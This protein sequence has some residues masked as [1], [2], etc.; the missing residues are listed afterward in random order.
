MVE[1]GVLPVTATSCDRG[2]AI[3]AAARIF[4]TYPVPTMPTCRGW[5]AL[6]TEKNK[7]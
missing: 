6:P 2:S 4:A 7:D 5:E 3:K 1:A